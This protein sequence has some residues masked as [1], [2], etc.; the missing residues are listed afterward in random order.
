MMCARLCVRLSLVSVLTND[1]RDCCLLH[2]CSGVSDPSAPVRVLDICV[3]FVSVIIDE[4]S[5]RQVIRMLYLKYHRRTRI[6][7]YETE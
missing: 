1:A 6:D 3:V 5:R 2:A 4:W 7:V